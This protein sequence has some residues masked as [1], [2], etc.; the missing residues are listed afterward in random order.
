MIGRPGAGL[1][2]DDSGWG[3]PAEDNGGQQ[4]QAKQAGK[5]GAADYPDLG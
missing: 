1:F 2:M 4:S 5:Q 3:F